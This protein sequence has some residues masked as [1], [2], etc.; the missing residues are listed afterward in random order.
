VYASRGCATFDPFGPG[1]LAPA[2]ASAIAI[3]ATNVL[4]FEQTNF[5]GSL[6]GD[7]F[8]LPGGTVKFAVGAEYRENTAQ[9]RPDQFLSSGDVVGF[10]AQQPVDG[11]INVTEPFAELS[12]PILSEVPFFN[13]LGLDLG[14]RYSD[15]NLAG[16]ADAYKASLE[17]N[18]IRSLKLRGGYN[19]SIRAPN[20]SELFL[21]VQENFPAATDPCNANSTFR[22]ASNPNKAAVEALCI[23]QGIPAGAMAAYSQPAP[24]LKSFIGG[25]VDLKPETADGYSF[26][27]VYQSDSDRELLSRLNV[28]VDYYKI[29]IDD[30]ITN[31]TTSS[32]VGRCFNQLNSNPSYDPG[33]TFCQSFTR[34]SNFGVVDVVTTTQNLSSFRG[35]GVDVNLNWGFP[36]DAFNGSDLDFKLLWTH[37][38]SREQQETLVD[39]FIPREGTISSTIGSAYPENKAVLSTTWSL[40]NV[41]VRYNLRY[42]EGMDVVNNDAILSPSTGA[43]PSIEDYLYH[44]LTVRWNINDTFGL[45]GG[46][47]NIEDKQPPVYTT[48][49]GVGIQANTDPSTY[50]VLGRRY[51][52][53]LTAK[54]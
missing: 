4:E 39:P 47:L 6:T 44:D 32:V 26:G 18:P 17:W 10:N 29:Q 20:I 40:Y 53:N 30:V 16:G 22:A 24:Q 33:N 45:T 19:R 13:Y 34:A 25:N 1:N 31:L 41:Q 46:A 36:M 2:C 27:I 3:A 50:D 21:P 42:I 48:S 9:F 51:F 49:S 52:L 12:I 23:A 15:Y 54:F 38:L 14:Y 5:V 43:A 35:D 8:D 7:V 28:S 37:L 11:V